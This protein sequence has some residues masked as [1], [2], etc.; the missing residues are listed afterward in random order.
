MH[1]KEAPDKSYKLT[2]PQIAALCSIFKQVERKVELGQSD[3]ILLPPRLLGVWAAETRVD[4][5]NE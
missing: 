1:T 5:I 3:Q 2:W 4:P